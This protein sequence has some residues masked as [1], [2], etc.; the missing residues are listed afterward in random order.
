MHYS[1]QRET[2]LGDWIVS[3]LHDDAPRTRKAPVEISPGLQRRQQQHHKDQQG[4]QQGSSLEKP[5]APS[6]VPVLSAACSGVLICRR[7]RKGRREGRGTRG[8]R[9]IIRHSAPRLGA[10]TQRGG[11]LEKRSAAVRAFSPGYIPP[12]CLLLPRWSSLPT[13]LESQGNSGKLMR[14][15][16]NFGFILTLPGLK[17]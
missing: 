13:S 10:T 7:V 12:A 3:A 5:L 8:L 16:P 4:Q 6:T 11:V 1:V 2:A 14:G 15:L 9:L 17:S